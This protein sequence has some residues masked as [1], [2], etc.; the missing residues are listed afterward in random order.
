MK[1]TIEKIEEMNNACKGNLSIIHYQK[2]EINSY[3][4]TR[5]S[6]KS[7]YP[8]MQDESLKK[9]VDKTYKFLFSK[10]NKK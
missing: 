8:Y 9:L 7:S 2:W 3:G 5:L 6:I 1:T 4:D 10:K